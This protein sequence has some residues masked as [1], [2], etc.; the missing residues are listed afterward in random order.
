M[1]WCALLDPGQIVSNKFL[2]CR[3][4]QVR[5]LSDTPIGGLLEPVES[6]LVAAVEFVT[7]LVLRAERKEL[8]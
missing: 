5:E 1:R 4:V 3:E 2:Q 7:A 6:G 8:R